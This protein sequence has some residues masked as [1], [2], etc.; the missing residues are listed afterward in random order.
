MFKK[1]FVTFRLSL[2]AHTELEN[3]K[4][5]LVH[6]YSKLAGKKN[7]QQLVRDRTQSFS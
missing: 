5:F 1:M 4:L 3:C 7:W 6:L 2:E